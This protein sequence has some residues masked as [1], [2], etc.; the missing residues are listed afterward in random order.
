M[1]GA[2]QHGPHQLGHAGVQN[3]EGFS[4]GPILDVDDGREEHAGWRDD[5]AAW[6]EDERQAGF[7]NHRKERR[8]VVLRGRDLAS[9]VRHAK[10][11]ADVE[12]IDRNP[13]VFQ[14]FR[15][16]HDSRGGTL[17]RVDIGNLRTHMGMQPGEF[18]PFAAGKATAD[19]AYGVGRHTKLVGF[20]SG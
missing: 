20:Q 6:F 14:L 2:V 10:A 9:V 12:M 4:V 8:R 11:A 7:S 17:Q 16:R 3:H 5:V 18:E 19:V 13:V 1:K 15:Q